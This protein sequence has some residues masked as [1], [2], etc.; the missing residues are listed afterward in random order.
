MSSNN[1][2][3]NNLS[4]NNSGLDN[5]SSNNSG[6]DN[7]GFDPKKKVTD[8]FTLLA[9]DWIDKNYDDSKSNDDNR[10]ACIDFYGKWFVDDKIFSHF[11]PLCYNIAYCKYMSANDKSND[12]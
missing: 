9:R 8:G 3:S 5:S 7:L 2:S 10:K 1:L 11:F 12:K 6:L 4:S